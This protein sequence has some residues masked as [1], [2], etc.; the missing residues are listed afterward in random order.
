MFHLGVSWA[1]DELS[2]AT[3]ARIAGYFATKA[4]RSLGSALDSPGGAAWG[5]RTHRALLL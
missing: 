5:G 4:K 2:R 3:P 1:G